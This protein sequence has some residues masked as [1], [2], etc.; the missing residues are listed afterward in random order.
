MYSD[1]DL[2]DDFDYLKQT[3]EKKDNRESLRL[4]KVNNYEL[5]KTLY[6]SNDVLNKNLNKTLNKNLNF[7]H[8]FNNLQHL[9]ITSDRLTN[10]DCLKEASLSYLTLKNTRIEY[11]PELTSLVCLKVSDNN[12]IKEIPKLPIQILKCCNL[13]L[14]KNISS[15]MVEELTI[16]SC[17]S[18][19]IVCCKPRKYV[20]IIGTPINSFKNTPMPKNLSKIKKIAFKTLFYY[21]KYDLTMEILTFL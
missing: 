19:E 2:D 1:N 17:K 20:E 10:I 8:K 5:F 16:R 15:T 9:H 7:F 21:F 4:Q 12:F 6:S 14:L 3:T 11:I 13:P 18:L